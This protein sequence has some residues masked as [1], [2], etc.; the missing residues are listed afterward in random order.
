MDLVHQAREAY[1]RTNCPHF[2][3]ET[4]HDLCGLFQDMIASVN[5]D[6][7]IYKIQE[8]W[9]GREDLRY[10][11]NVLKTSSKGLQFFHPISPSELSKAMGLKGIHHLDALCHFA[12][13]TFCPWCG[14][15]SQN[16]G[17]IV[18][19]LRTVHY[20]M[21]LAR[22]GCLRST[23]ITSEAMQHHGQGCKQPREEDGG[24]NN[25]STSK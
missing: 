2:N 18:N 12:S 6:S 24:P 17:T 5:L 13:V 20:N 16:K 15:E 11:N 3:C 7:K 25:T 1:F 21:G 10:A 9:T 4:S 22:D 14:K 23:A 19:H 8:A